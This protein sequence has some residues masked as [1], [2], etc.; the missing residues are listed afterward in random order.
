MYFLGLLI[1]IPI[2][3]LYTDRIGRAN[4]DV[5]QTGRRQR[6]ARHLC[7]RIRS[8]SGQ[9]TYALVRTAR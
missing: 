4:P 9:I 2:Q 8:T 3:I 7:N 1:Y 6:E 5:I